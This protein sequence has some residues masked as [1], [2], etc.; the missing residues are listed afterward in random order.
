MGIDVII[1]IILVKFRFAVFTITKYLFVRITLSC[2][3]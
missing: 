3:P 2:K 1:E